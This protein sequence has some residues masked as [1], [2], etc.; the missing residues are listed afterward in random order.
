MEG[1]GDARSFSTVIASRTSNTGREPTAGW[2]SACSDS[3]KRPFGIHSTDRE[4]PSG[5]GESWPAAGRAGS[6]MNIAS[7]TWWMTTAFTFSQHAITTENEVEGFVPRRSAAP[8]PVDAPGQD[9]NPLEVEAP[10]AAVVDDAAPVLYRDVEAQGVVRP[11][12]GGRRIRP[13]FRSRP[14]CRCAGGGELPD[15]SMRRRSCRR[16][17]GIAGHQGRWRYIHNE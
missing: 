7:S 13:G 8:S 10:V 9:P 16:A 2:R 3:S 6:T 5:S 1:R 15:H 4:S 17:T 14:R 11:V 12:A